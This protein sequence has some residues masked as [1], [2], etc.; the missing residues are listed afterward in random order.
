MLRVK[1]NSTEGVNNCA[2][3][4]DVEDVPIG[5]MVLRP[6]EF[7]MRGYTEAGVD[8]TPSTFF[9]E[10]TDDLLLQLHRNPRGVSTHEETICLSDIENDAD[11]GSDTNEDAIELPL[12]LQNLVD[13]AMEQIE[14]W[15]SSTLG[16]NSCLPNFWH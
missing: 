14:W 4:A 15:T 12:H 3:N 8:E 7:L 16:F 1:P 5:Q 10:D 2:L 9:G 11:T 13:K 6:S